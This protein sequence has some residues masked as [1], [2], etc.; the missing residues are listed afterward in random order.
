[1][2]PFTANPFVF[3]FSGLLLVAVLA[4]FGWGAL[5]RLGLAEEQA[6][7][8]VVRKQLNPPG[9][10][11]RT[12]IAGGRAWTLTDPT[13]ETYVLELKIGDEPTVAVVGKDLYDALGPGDRV[14]L[15]LHRT[16][17]S[18][19]LEVTHVSR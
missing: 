11:Y 16:R 3:I 5:D 1:M 9:V 2:T 6:S 10:T 18:G 4:Y 14:Q 17:L 15:R 7:A 8:V 12:T 19:R 13:S